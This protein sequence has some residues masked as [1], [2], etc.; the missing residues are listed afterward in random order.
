MPSDRIIHYQMD[1]V[2]FILNNS[3]RMAVKT[4]TFQQNDLQQQQQRK[5]T[6]WGKK[7]KHFAS[8]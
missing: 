2:T 8:Y 7:K 1:S 6:Q 5:K 4:G 3:N